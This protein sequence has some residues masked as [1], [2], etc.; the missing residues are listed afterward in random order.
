MIRLFIKKLL[1][2]EFY[3]I[4]FLLLFLFATAMAT[5]QPVVTR[6]SL[7]TCGPGKEIYELEGHTALRLTYDD[8]RELSVNWGIFD[9]NSPNFLY[10][11]V[12]GETDYRM[13]VYPFQNFLAQYTHEGRWMSERVLDLDSL[14]RQRLAALIDS[15]LTIGS[16]VYRYNYVL[17]NC[18][19]RPIDYVAM[20]VGSPVTLG[21]ETGIAV[22]TS[23]FRQDMT[24]YHRNYPW[25][26]F[27][28]DL[29]LGRGI[30][31]PI[32]VAEHRFAPVALDRMLEHAT[33]TD[34]LGNKRQLASQPI[35][36]LPQSHG[37][38][39][40]PTPWPLR[41]LTVCWTFFAI[42]LAVCLYDLRRL[43]L[44][45]WY[46]SAYYT[47]ASLAGLLLTFLI[48]VSV[49]ESTSPNWL[50]L[51]LNPV[52]LVGAVAIWLKKCN[53]IYIWW[54]FANFVAL[55]VL[56]VIATLGVQRLNP[57]F[58]PLVFADMLMALTSLLIFN[59][60]Q[61]K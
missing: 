18:A 22:P 25:Y 42:T 23:T 27:G 20:A 51:W 16:P 47:I 6:V 11:F 49:H 57:A 39:L 2:K 14:Q 30:D 60:K 24:Y 31:R 55:T 41:P 53:R 7:V 48:F 59:G 28:I 35:P 8:G 50:Y 13:A 4:N 5:A 54:Q 43:R 17:D 9:F 33:V 38:P 29:A 36:I 40:G 19:T 21:T 44:T 52:C 15:T 46:F 61:R 3:S 58:F 56:L 32:T 37:E 45:R 12:K 34:S 26:Q 10:R 1:Q